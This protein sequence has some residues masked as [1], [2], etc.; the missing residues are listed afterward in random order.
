MDRVFS[1]TDALLEFAT[2][3]WRERFVTEDLITRE[4]IDVF[5]KRPFFLL[6]NVEAPISSQFL[7]RKAYVFL[8]LWLYNLYLL[9]QT[10]SV[11]PELDLE[12]FIEEHDF[13]TWASGPLTSQTNNPTTSLHT[14]QPFVN[15]TVINNFPSVE[16]LWRHLSELDLLNSERLRP[17]WDSY[18]M[19]G[20]T[21][22]LPSLP[23][24]DLMEDLGVF[25]GNAFELY[26]AES[27]GNTRQE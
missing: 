12:S 10:S 8:R 22:V 6:V 26:E 5:S 21:L 17:S 18:F 1:G 14:L 4:A 9:S 16:Q 2:H 7:R 24:T 3:H 15:V 25:G 19:V 13:L 27:G 23:F 11:Q 20:F